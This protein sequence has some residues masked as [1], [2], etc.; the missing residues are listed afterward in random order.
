V[1]TKGGE[2]KAAGIQRVGFASFPCCGA[3]KNQGQQE[4]LTE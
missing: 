2:Y 4:N 1:K 3:G